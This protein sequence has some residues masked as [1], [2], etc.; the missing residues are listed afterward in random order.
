MTKQS[1]N[2]MAEKI[3]GIHHHS[4]SE[5]EELEGLFPLAYE[6]ILKALRVVEDVEN[7]HVT[8]GVTKAFRDTFKIEARTFLNAAKQLSKDASAA[9]ARRRQ[10]ERR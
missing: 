7:V 6:L 4:A 9:D 5:R 8:E 2:V 3:A 1:G 10:A